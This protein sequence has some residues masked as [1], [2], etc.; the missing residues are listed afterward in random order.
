[1]TPIL[2]ALRPSP[3]LPED[4]LVEALSRWAP[5]EGRH[6][7]PWPGLG[8]VRASS[9][10]ARFPVVYEPCLCF[11]AQG[12]KRVF[13]GD[14]VYT[15]DPR[16]YLVLGMHLPAE[17]EIFQASPEEPYLSL[18]LRIDGAELSDLLVALAADPAETSDIGDGEAPQAAR[19]DA[20]CGICVSRMND[21]LTDALG[22]LLAALDDPLERRI[23]APLAIREILY[24]VLAG[25]QGSLLRAIALHDSRS[26]R[27]AQV[28]RY[29]RT[30]YE[31][32]LDITT[33][34]RAA[35]M[36]PS[37]LHHT[38][39]EVTSVSP[40][41]YLKQ[42]RL[43][44]AR[45]LMLNDGLGSGEVAFRVGYGSAS[46]FSREFKRLFGVP[47]TSSAQSLREE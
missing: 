28:L 7:S 27:I 29:L 26:Q 13:L 9:P 5:A 11:V 10:S 25:E 4:G 24:H 22:R 46:Q 1:M 21:R 39:K 17:A 30:H 47:P 43:H 45:L 37:T 40:L 33:I 36:S 23:L 44:Q 2:E 41:Q 8:F 18:A 42:I 35:R 16:N 15:F 6:P 19:R 32:P 34:A 14:R 38:F 31:E 3:S 12:S 20:P